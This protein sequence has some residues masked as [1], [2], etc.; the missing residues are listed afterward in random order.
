M[1][2]RFL[3]FIITNFA[4]TLVSPVRWFKIKSPLREFVYIRTLRVHKNSPH[5]RVC[6]IFIMHGSVVLGVV[7]YVDE[8]HG[9]AQTPTTVKK[10]LSS[11]PHISNNSCL[12]Q[13]TYTNYSGLGFLTS[14]SHEMPIYIFVTSVAF[15]T[16]NVL[17]FS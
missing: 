13:N 4:I 7:G 14:S 2:F 12:T 17:L 15:V 10:Y 6:K 8:G 11:E 5:T 9:T 16:T 1:K 3:S